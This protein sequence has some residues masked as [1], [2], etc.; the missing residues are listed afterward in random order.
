MQQGIEA[1]LEQYENTDGD[2]DIP[3]MVRMM[4]DLHFSPYFFLSLSTIE[5]MVKDNFIAAKAYC[6]YA[7]QF[8]GKYF[9]HEREERAFTV[10]VDQTEAFLVLYAESLERQNVKR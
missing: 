10:L 9:E 8:L 6:D 7:R 3:D 1:W 2:I 4:R 5:A